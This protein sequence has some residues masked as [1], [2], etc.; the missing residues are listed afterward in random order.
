VTSSSDLPVGFLAQVFADGCQC[1]C[2]KKG[3][4]E[5]ERLREE[6]KKL[7]YERGS[8]IKTIAEISHGTM[9]VGFIEEEMAKAWADRIAREGR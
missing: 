5:I 7:H 8:L 4:A 6:N 3:K 9:S 2:C 1:D